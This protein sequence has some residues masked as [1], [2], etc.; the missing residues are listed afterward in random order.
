M[1]RLGLS[2]II[3]A[4]LLAAGWLYRNP[5][6]FKREV[7]EKRAEHSAPTARPQER[8]KPVERTEDIPRR[9]GVRSAYFTG[10]THLS[11]HDRA[12]YTDADPQIM[13]FAA[14]LYTALRK[15]GIPVFIHCCYRDKATQTEVNH[16]GNSKASWGRSP[17]NSGQAVDIIHSIFGWEMDEDEW[18]Y[19]GRI[20]KDVART[21]GLE[22][23]WGGDWRYYDPAHWQL[24]PWDRVPVQQ[25]KTKG[26]NLRRTPASILRMFPRR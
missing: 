12:D 13:E 6:V 14:R 19:I 4:A 10:E 18:A 1:S 5:G 26:D 7:A 2:A 17:H 16:K 23:T 3:N 15:R 25:L 11:Q 9:L 8:E 24:D 20:G 21:M 22:V